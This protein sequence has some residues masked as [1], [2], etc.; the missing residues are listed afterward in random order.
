[1]EQD[2][3]QVK[4]A[5]YISYKEPGE[6]RFI[7][8][9]TL[10]SEYSDE[11]IKERIAGIVTSPIKKKSTYNGNH[12]NLIINIKNN[13]KTQESKKVNEEKYKLFS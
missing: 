13:L 9:I 10:G 1:M 12:I 11:R 7:G 6:D 5:K 2:N 8:G 4:R 3:Y